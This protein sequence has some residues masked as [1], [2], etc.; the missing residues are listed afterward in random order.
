MSEPVSERLSRF[1]PDA[2]GLDRDALLFEAGRASARPGWHWKGL[3]AALAA[4]QLLTLWLLW[5]RTPTTGS[6][7]PAPPALTPAAPPGSGESAEPSG[8]WTLN[9]RLRDGQTDPLPP[10]QSVE[11]LP[12]DPPP[13]HPVVPVTSPLLD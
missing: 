4:S 7:S 1:T 13:L 10:P 5:P 3:A 12:P 6:P 11:K 9:R 2:S 8:L